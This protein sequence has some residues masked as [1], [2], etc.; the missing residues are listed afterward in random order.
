[1]SALVD[2]LAV[3]RRFD[4]AHHTTLCAYPTADECQA[5]H[6]AVA[7]LAD[8]VRALP[9]YCSVSTQLSNGASLPAVTCTRCELLT[10]AGCAA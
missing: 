3:I 9:C 6:A 2:V 1:M 5:A 8:F 7:E 4:V 10:R